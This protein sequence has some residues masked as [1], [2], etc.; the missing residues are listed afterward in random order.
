MG[1]LIVLFERVFRSC[2]V[3]VPPPPAEVNTDFVVVAI[4]SPP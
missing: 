1:F 3:F 2:S 4:G